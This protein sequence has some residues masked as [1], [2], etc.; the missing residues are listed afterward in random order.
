[1]KVGASKTGAKLSSHLTNLRGMGDASS[2]DAIGIKLMPVRLARPL[3]QPFLKT[4]TTISR[5]SHIEIWSGQI[6]V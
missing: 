2:V 3:H 5:N 1:M 6:T 4:K